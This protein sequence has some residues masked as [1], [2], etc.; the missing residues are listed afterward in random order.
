VTSS[1]KEKKKKKIH[2]SA[3]EISREAAVITGFPVMSDLSLMLLAW[4]T[5]CKLLLL[6]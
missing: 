4:R 2:C 3:V 6:L 1:E 5:L